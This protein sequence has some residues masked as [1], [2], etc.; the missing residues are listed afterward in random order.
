MPQLDVYWNKIDH[1]DTSKLSMEELFLMRLAAERF[2][3]DTDEAKRNKARQFLLST[4]LISEQE[5][6][7]SAEEEVKRWE[8]P[9]MIA[10]R[11]SDIHA[12]LYKI[13]YHQEGKQYILHE[14]SFFNKDENNQFRFTHRFDLVALAKIYFNSTTAQETL[15]RQI[16]DSV[17]HRKAL[18]VEDFSERGQGKINDQA[19]ILKS[20][21]IKTGGVGIAANQCLA[22]EEPWQIIL[23]G[24]DYT[25]PE[26]VVKALT[27]YPTTLFPSMQIYINPSIIKLSDDCESFAEGCLSVK[28]GLR[29]QVLRAS[30]VTIGYQD[31]TGVVQNKMLSGSDARVMLHEVDHIL[32]G[33]VYMQHVIEELTATQLNIFKKILEQVLPS[34]LYNQANPFLSPTEIF[35]RN[36]NGSL[37]F[38][39]NDLREAL[40]KIPEHTLKG[41]YK[42]LFTH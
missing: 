6:R 30:T 38:N 35:Q 28:G 2:I 14:I 29:A 13:N 7:F 42:M 16:G 34:V 22:V 9:Q 37:V 24:V 20:V 39:E 33:K 36:E 41:M 17:L 3:A 10:Q 15:I 32:N 21:L 1:A 11:N 19:D 40:Q 31:I 23:A 26:H 5:Y 18:P 8:Y 27:R 4:M 12:V 25:N